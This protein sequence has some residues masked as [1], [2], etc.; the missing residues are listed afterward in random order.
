[1]D[2]DMA[3]CNGCAPSWILQLTWLLYSVVLPAE[4]LVAIGYWS[5]EYEPGGG[6]KLINLYKHGIIAAVLLLWDGN[7]VIFGN[8]TGDG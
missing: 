6:D 3:V 7:V 8:G 4:F 1:M 2:M 5:F